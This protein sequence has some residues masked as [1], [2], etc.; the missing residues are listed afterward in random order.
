VQQEEEED[1]MVG[2]VPDNFEIEKFVFGY[3]GIVCPSI[4]DSHDYFM[5]LLWESII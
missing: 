4:W 5:G 2:I 3:P 1:V